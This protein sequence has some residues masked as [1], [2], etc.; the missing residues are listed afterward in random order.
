PGAAIGGALS[1]PAPCPVASSARLRAMK[2]AVWTEPWPRRVRACL[3]GVTVADST[4]VLLLFEPGHRPVYYFPPDDV[5]TDLLEP[6]AK[7]T[8]CPHKGQ[9]SYWTI[10]AGSS[11]AEDAV[12][13]YL[14]PIPERSDITGHMAFYWNR[15]DA[16][17]EE[18]DEVSVH[19]RDPHHRV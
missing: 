2:P 15:L 18:D 8:H 10:R 9:A 1:T 3:G 4:R 17:F 6:T 7:S 19:A 16:W 14:D 13:S 11:V 5:R 12:W